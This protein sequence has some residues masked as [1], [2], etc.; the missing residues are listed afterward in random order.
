MKTKKLYI[1]EYTFKYLGI[2]LTSK[3]SFVAG[4]GREAVNKLIKNLPRDEKLLSIDS[5]EKVVLD[6]EE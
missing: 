1:L 4:N 5:V 6:H 3:Q 2:E